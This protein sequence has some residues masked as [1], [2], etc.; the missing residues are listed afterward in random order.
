MQTSYPAIVSNSGA[1]L[2]WALVIGAL[3]A[4]GI[5]AAFVGTGA[6]FP[7]LGYATWPGKATGLW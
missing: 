5:A 4:V 7:G 1:M 2:M 3:T 6:I